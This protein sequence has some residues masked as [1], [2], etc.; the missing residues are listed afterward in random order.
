MSRRSLGLEDTVYDYLL[1]ESLREPALLADLRKETAALPEA[2]MQISPEQGQFMQLLVE[3]MGARLAVEVGT[4]T[5][6]SALSVALAMPSDGRLVCCDLSSDYT[7][8][9]KPYWARAGVADKIDLRIGPALDTLDGL[10]EEGCAGRVDF[11]FVDA[12]KTNYDG[13]YERGLKL[14]RQ[15]GLLAIDNVL[16]NGSV[17]DPSNRKE[18]TE[19]IRALNSKLH[20]DERITLSMLPVGDGLTLARKR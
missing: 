1:R 7:D 8:I 17:A 12:D 13:Y 3:L 4:F 9:G 19:A 20:G 5:G 6:Y 11:M 16:W 10:L 15:G 2:G 18:T 14:L